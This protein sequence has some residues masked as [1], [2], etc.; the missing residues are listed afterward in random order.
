MDEA[1]G[2]ARVFRSFRHRDFAVFWSGNFLSNIGT[3]M[4]TVALGWLVLEITDS[5]WMVGVNGFVSAAPT[6]L[7]TLIGGAIADR[8]DRRRLM[9]VMQFGMLALALLLGT[10]TL[11]EKIDLRSILVIAFLSGLAMAINYPAYQALYPELVKEEDL[12]NAVALNSAQFNIAR[13]VGPTVAG[14]ALGA[15]GVAACFYL[16]AVSFL[17][18]IVALLFIRPPQFIPH[19]G[20]SVWQAMREGFGFVGERR[21]ILLLL[22][23]SGFLSL[24]GLPFVILM[25]VFARDLLGVGA[26]GLGYLMGG[27][28]LGA[29]LCA[30]VLAY[31]GEPRNKSRTITSSAM[32]FSL[33]LVGFSMSGSFWLSFG[34]LSVLG[35]AMVGTLA[36][37]NTSIQRLTP[38]RMRGRVMSMYNL[39]LLGLAPLGSL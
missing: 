11:L 3:W 25:P 34:L 7:F 30:I 28:G 10:L 12:L 9:L 27:A 4:Q 22:S 8:V 21:L 24:F 32:T 1:R 29:S 18:L 17:G 26:S 39:S 16:N 35:A 37:T 20:G 5:A 13:A 6:L 14:L 38:P 36:V 23:V 19:K 31:I 15:V 2:F 33:A